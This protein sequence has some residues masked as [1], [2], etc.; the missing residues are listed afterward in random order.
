MSEV[1]PAKKVISWLI[2]QGVISSQKDFGERIGI[3]SRSYLS[4]LVS[5]PTNEFIDKLCLL[6]SNINRDYLLTGEGN[7]LLNE[8]IKSDIA[9]E[10][11]KIG[12]D[13]GVPYYDEDFVLGF[14]EIG[15]PS[16]ERPQF[17]VQIPKYANATLWCNATGHSMEPEINSGD[18]IALQVID[19]PS[20]LLFGDL[21]AIVTTNGL[22]TIKRLGRGHDEEHYRLI[23]T[24]K[25]YDEQEIPKKVILRVFKVLGNLH[26]F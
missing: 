18:V 12:F 8:E 15:F 14:N 3:T 21:Y 26:S 11:T 13:K 22:R 6:D 20:F 10:H 5:N 1:K 23:P 19:D 16:S 17:L 24:N 9:V 2:S 25:D 7:M 4:Q